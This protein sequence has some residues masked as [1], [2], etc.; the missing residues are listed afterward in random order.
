MLDILFT[1]TMCLNFLHLSN[2]LRL[3]TTVCKVYFRVC[4]ITITVTQLTTSQSRVQQAT[5]NVSFGCISLLK[6]LRIEE[7]VSKTITYYYSSFTSFCSESFRSELVTLELGTQKTTQ[8]PSKTKIWRTYYIIYWKFSLTELLKT[9]WDGVGKVV[10]M[11]LTRLG[12]ILLTKF[13]IRLTWSSSR[14][15]WCRCGPRW[16]ESRAP[17]PPCCW[18]SVPWR[19]CRDPV[20]RSHHQRGSPWW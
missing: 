5:I 12:W 6:C 2:H 17:H 11:T 1:F 7:R 4:L 10:H 13:R 3:V 15:R 8:H 16:R 19:W 18:T 20:A 9:D 14:L